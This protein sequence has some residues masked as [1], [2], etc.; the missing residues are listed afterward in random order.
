MKVVQVESQG[1]FSG[2][3]ATIIGTDRD[4]YDK[5]IFAVKD[6]VAYDYLK[7]LV[8]QGFSLWDK[9][10]IAKIDDKVVALNENEIKKTKTKKESKKQEE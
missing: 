10:Y 3:S 5:S 4:Y 8:T 9:V 1:P 6:Q 7:R 2:S